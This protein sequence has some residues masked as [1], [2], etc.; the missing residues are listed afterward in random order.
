MMCYMHPAD[1]PKQMN[2]GWR[3]QRLQGG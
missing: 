2:W 1:Q 3:F